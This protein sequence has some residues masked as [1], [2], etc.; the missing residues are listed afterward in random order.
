[1]SKTIIDRERYNQLSTSTAGNND[2][3]VPPVAQPA[4]CEFRHRD[5]ACHQPLRRLSAGEPRMAWQRAAGRDHHATA[6]ASAHGAGILFAGSDWPRFGVRKIL[7]VDLRL[8]SG[9]HLAGG[10]G[11]RAVS[12]DTAAD[13]VHSGGAREY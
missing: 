6:G 7:R 1:M 4:C 12:L 3:L 9:F 5:L 2:R 8:A 11:S 13:Q 10:D